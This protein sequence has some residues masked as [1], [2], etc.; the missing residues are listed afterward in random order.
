MT[1][2]IRDITH[3]GILHRPKNYLSDSISNQS[4]EITQYWTETYIKTYT[5]SDNIDALLEDALQQGKQYCLIQESG[6]M[7]FDHTFY[8][9]LIPY[10][11]S[12]NWFA[13]A[14]IIAKES[15]GIHPQ[16]VF[17]NVNNWN[18]I[19]KPK[20]QEHAPV[21][22]VNLIVPKRSLSNIHDDY[23]PLWI[24]PSKDTVTV[25][26]YQPGWGWINAALE[27]GLIVRNFTPDMRKYKV[28]LYPDKDHLWYDMQSMILH[29]LAVERTKVFFDN[30]EGIRGFE[31]RPGIDNFYL[32]ASGFKPNIIVESCGF[33]TDTTIC[34]ID[35]S[36]NAL[37]FKRWLHKNWDGRNY[38]ETVRHYVTQIPALYESVKFADVENHW[39]QVIEF[40]GS[41]DQFAEHWKKFN[42]CK[43]NYLLVD[44]VGFQRN[45]LL[46]VID[47]QQS[48]AIWWSHAFNTFNSLM[49]KGRAG[50]KICYE[51]WMQ[52]L[53]KR[54][55]NIVTFSCYDNK[56]DLL[57]SLPLKDYYNGSI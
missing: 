31:A 40:F 21:D 8:Q 16:T 28:F 47:P 22:A 49:L 44:I 27:A 48:N 30:T 9:T 25:T 41:E 54:D 33:N 23:T 15:T 43:I 38:V 57:P 42:S 24:L 4:F 2:D 46:N 6:N 17:V 26:D 53:Y 5:V 19:G 36:G 50:A 1:L 7:I 34:Y 52:D 39:N 14:H 56:Q 10:L 29:S 35:Y 37:E 18:K 45:Y 55:P 11:N 20:Y 12:D 13:I 3:F 51:H 32:V